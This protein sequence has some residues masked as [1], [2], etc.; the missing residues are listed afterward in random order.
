MKTATAIAAALALF[1]SAGA[2]AEWITCAKEGGNCAFAGRKEVSFGSGNRWFTRNF[3]D[4][5]KC[6]TLSFG[7]DPSPGVVKTC[8][9]NAASA[10]ASTQWTSCARE[11]AACAFT[12]RKEVSYGSGSKW[13]T[14]IF[15]NGVKCASENFLGDPAPGVAKSCRV[16]DLAGGAS[17]SWVR[18]A[19]EGQVCRFSGDRNVA[20]GAGKRLNYRVFRN[21]ATC[22]SRNFGD[23]APGAS[24]SCFYDA[25]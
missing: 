5:V 8:R 21:G 15:A 16:R 19:S 6:S 10:S 2:A 11:G 13:V 18:C 22:S 23:P 24:K 7:G 17:P 3:S 12:G 9:I 20:Y 14:T 25:N 4:G 1:A